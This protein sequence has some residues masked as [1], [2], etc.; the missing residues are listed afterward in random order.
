M[1]RK[2]KLHP[3]EESHDH[4]KDDDRGDDNPDPL[5]YLLG[6]VTKEEIHTNKLILV[7]EL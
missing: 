1:K 4:A 7:L 2:G 6:A 3:H 5:D